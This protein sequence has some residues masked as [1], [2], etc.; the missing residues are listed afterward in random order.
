M[1]AIIW[2][3]FSW[4]TINA[5]ETQVD[6]IS[7]WIKAYIHPGCRI[8]TTAVK[9]RISLQQV[10]FSLQLNFHLII[11][12]FSSVNL[13]VIFRSCLVFLYSPLIDWCLKIILLYKLQS[14]SNGSPPHFFFYFFFE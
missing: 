2:K 11:I 7:K 4:L 3:A 14:H 10:S 6:L 12:K 1:Q 8:V 5:C 9:F 13:Q